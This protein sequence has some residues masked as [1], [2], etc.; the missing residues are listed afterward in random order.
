M[1]LE[2]EHSITKTE[3]QMPKKELSERK[4]KILTALV[5]DYIKSAAPVSS[6]DI[7]AKYLPEVS[8][9]T[10]RSELNALEA[11]GYIDKP[12][13]SAGRV[14]LAEAY[15][16]YCERAFVNREFSESDLS[17]MTKRFS[18]Q[19]SDVE[20]LSAEAAKIISDSTNYTSVVVTNNLSDVE[21]EEIK[22]VG[23]SNGLA[24]VLIVTNCGIITDK[25][26]RLPDDVLSSGV[27]TASKLLN[28]AFKGKRVSDLDM[29]SE[30][31]TIGENLLGYKQV[32][33]EIID[34][35]RNYSLE[36]RKSIHVEGALKVLDYSDSPSDVKNFLQL[37]GD[38]ESLEKLVAT[39]DD[40]IE[41]SLKIGSD[42]NGGI[43]KCAIVTA[44]Y[45]INGQVIGQAGV[46]G[47][48]RMDYK[49][50]LSV[51]DGI[52]K[53]LENV[54]DGDKVEE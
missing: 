1:L 28:K 42:E 48:E 6:A 37:M 46:I 30:L 5:D 7:Q 52:K 29:E 18:K 24:L 41:L 40:N 21:I 19:A 10:I 54:F 47:P 9:A 33:G 45:K 3:C 50:V 35:L 14:P 15:K 22:L 49:K 20:T 11:L 53:S 32:F 51:L 36:K 12:H 23:L 25:A 16:L 34:I 44:E 2:R 43:D 27:E 31:K 39:P 38:S 4:E 8:S 17:E 13:T 26:I